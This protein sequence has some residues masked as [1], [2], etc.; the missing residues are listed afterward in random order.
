[1]ITYQVFKP[2]NQLLS[3]H[4]SSADAIKAALVFEHENNAFAYVEQVRHQLIG[5]WAEIEYLPEG[6]II[7]AYFSFGSIGDDDA[8]TDSYGIS[9][10][11][12][13]Y[14]CDGGEYE[15]QQ[16]M[17]SDNDFRVLSYE[18]EYITL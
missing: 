7:S 17:Q 4:I 3:E 1:M 11:K 14:Y 16:L 10:E 18:L 9:D 12:I 2:N 6:D 8:V 13:F 15:I 5:A